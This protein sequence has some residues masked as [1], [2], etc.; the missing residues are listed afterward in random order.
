M[1]Q[2]SI[3]TQCS[4]A[5]KDLL[6]T[7]EPFCESEVVQRA[8]RD[9]W[10]EREFAEAD[11]HAPQILASLYRNSRLVRFGVV[12]PEKAPLTGEQDYVRRDGFIL[13]A[14]YDHWSKK[15][16]KTPNGRFE[17]I[18]Y[19]EDPVF[20]VGRRKSSE[21][22]DFTPW[23]EQIPTEADPRPNVTAL[24]REVTHLRA[25]LDAANARIAELEAQK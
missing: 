3:Y 1:I 5:A 13:Y 17:P 10:T 24:K 9:D 7:G 16:L 11:R 2:N 18:L 21:R 12:D 14:D 8:M 4:I 6:A 20:K 19:R 25:K 22:D 23:A 15:A